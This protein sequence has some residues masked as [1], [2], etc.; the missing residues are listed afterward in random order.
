MNPHATLRLLFGFDAPVDRR[1]YLVA[2]T[3]LMALKYGVDALV[4]WLRNGELWHPLRYLSPF[5]SV[6]QNA[7][8]SPFDTTTLALMAIWTLPFLWIGASMSVR[9]AMHAGLSP[10]VGLLFLVPLVNWFTIAVLAFL[11]G[12]PPMAQA[13]PV[14]A[15]EGPAAR[16]ESQGDSI[17]LAAFKGVAVGVGLAVGTTA[18]S[19]LLLGSYGGALF[20]GT[21][22]V[23]GFF[24][25]WFL[26]RFVDRGM[27]PTMGV[28][29]LALVVAGGAL[30][31]FALEGLFCLL[32]AFP[33]AL[34]LGAVGALV[35]RPVAGAGHQR[36]HHAGVLLA[37]IPFVLAAEQLD[38]TPPVREVATGII[39]N[40]PPEVVWPNVVGFAD[41]PNDNLPWYFAMGIAYPQRAVIEGQGVGAVRYCEFSTGPFVEPITV[42]DEPH[43]LAFDVV[44]Q[45]PCMHE[46]S[47][48]NRVNA[49]HVEGYIVSHRGEFRLT[50]LP[51]GRTRLE[52]STWYHLDMAPQFYWTIWSDW[53]L[54]SIH[55]RVLHHVRDLSE[56]AVAR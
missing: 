11:P 10:A 25:S 2:G 17:T 33:I 46:W 43:R 7:L 35:G 1:A 13:V 36:G 50:A 55:Y 45:P 41:L 12:R 31:L 5:F 49:P 32:M 42:W 4:V 3:T 52:G 22:F 19:T 30:M 8:E 14:H 18:V 38:P 29:A 26:N 37:L 48:W 16:Y 56:A 47:P 23:I 9:R 51:D 28:M 39:V 53:L 15:P 34:V 6:R 54:H 27:G 40:A 20:I 44:D 21:P 24:A